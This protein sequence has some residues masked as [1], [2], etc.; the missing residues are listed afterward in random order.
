MCHVIPTYLAEGRAA[1][2]A[3]AS[4][5]EDA[6]DTRDAL[7]ARDARDAGAAPPLPVAFAT[8]VEQRLRSRWR[9]PIVA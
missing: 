5:G 2:A 1:A 7:D 9:S 4:G 3:A 8:R 6:R